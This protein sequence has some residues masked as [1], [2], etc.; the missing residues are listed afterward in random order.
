MKLCVTL[1]EKEG[2]WSQNVDMNTKISSFQC[3]WI[4]RLYGDKFHEWKLISLNLIKSSSS[5]FH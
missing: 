2:G 1:L 4:K 5:L 3:S